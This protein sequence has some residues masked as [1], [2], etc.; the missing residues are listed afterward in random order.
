MIRRTHADVHES[1]PPKNRIIQSHD[2][3][4]KAK[5]LY[6]RVLEGVYERI[7]AY[8]ARGRNSQESVT[9][10]LVQIM[11]LKQVCA[12]DKV[13]ATSDLATQLAD[14]MEGQKHPKVL[15]FSQFKPAAYSIYQRLADQG[16]LCFVSDN[17]HDLITA[18]DNERD[19]L[20]QQFQNDPEIKYLV[21][22]EKTAKEGHDITQ[23]GTVIFNDLF[24]TP[25]NHSQG[26]GRAYMRESDPHG[27]DSYYM[28][29]DKD[30]GEIEEW[31]WELL[32]F[33]ES[34]IEETI[35]KVEGTR[36]VEGSVAMDLINK[37]RENMWRK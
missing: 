23:A 8:D 9:N 13:E 4:A 3:S 15:I 19:K 26:E 30:S 24:W 32:G 36:D 6:Q 16:A 2:L 33:K 14:S 1:L 29:V 11:R 10:I 5:K 28:I 37:L 20:V 7:Q 34:V 17:G 25:A 22:T 27:I 35:E 31:I 12:F 21:V 18:N